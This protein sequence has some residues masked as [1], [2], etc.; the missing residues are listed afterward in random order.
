MVGP[1]ASDVIAEATLAVQHRHTVQDL[2]LTMHAHPTM[3]EPLLQAALAAEG[4]AIEIPNR[5]RAAP[6]PAAAQPTAPPSGEETSSKKENVAVARR[7]AERK[8][9]SRARAEQSNGAAPATAVKD[10]ERIRLDK[11]HRDEL[12]SLYR[13]MFLIRRFEERAQAEYTRAE[14]GGYCHLTA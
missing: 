10:P 7:V 5:R 14:T 8:P 13:L 4:R 2:D 9:Q 6:H 3:A 1:H 12:L 11:A